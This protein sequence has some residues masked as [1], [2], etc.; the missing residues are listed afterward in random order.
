M[1]VVPSSKIVTGIS[2]NIRIPTK[3]S[4]LNPSEDRILRLVDPQDGKSYTKKEFLDYYGT[5]EVWRRVYEKYVAEG[6]S[7]QSVS[8]EMDRQD[9]I[10]GLEEKRI[11]PKD[12]NPYTKSDF[13][14][15]YGRLEEWNHAQA[16][17][18][19]IDPDGSAN[20]EGKGSASTMEEVETRERRVDS[21][22]GNVYTKAEFML[23]YGGL[24]EWEQARGTK[25]HAVAKHS[26]EKGWELSSEMLE[27]LYKQRLRRNEKKK[28]KKKT[29]LETLYLEK[30][31]EEKR[32]Q[33]R[34]QQYGDHMQV[35]QVRMLEAELNNRF[36]AIVDSTAYEIPFWPAAPLASSV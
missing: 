2:K 35:V 15:E 16:V 17:V 29:Q 19:T 14:Q 20:L 21:S 23:Q 18:A 28:R 7:E 13:L 32:K 10:E 3:K 5:D 22:D 4:R 26:D 27:I 25:D 1:E 6:A 11:D 9:M 33:A 8:L 36:D 34:M 30:Q 31:D 12:G 24:G